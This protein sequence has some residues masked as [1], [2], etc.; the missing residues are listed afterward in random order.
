MRKIFMHKL[1]EIQ[2]NNETAMNKAVHSNCCVNTVISPFSWIRFTLTCLSI[3]PWR[4]DIHFGAE[5]AEL[6]GWGDWFSLESLSLSQQRGM[7]LWVGCDGKQNCG[8]QTHTHT[9]TWA[10]CSLLFRCSQNDFLAD[11]ISVADWIRGG[12]GGGGVKV[13]EVS[14]VHYRKWKMKN[15][16]NERNVCQEVPSGMPHGKLIMYFCKFAM[17]LCQIRGAGQEASVWK[18][19]GP[20]RN[21]D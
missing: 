17:L 20:G 18:R 11:I 13:Q 3:K 1:W 12:A 10:G 8:A 15:E 5:I 19:S 6:V 7:V 4:T 16:R 9:H 2:H 21:A 14:Q